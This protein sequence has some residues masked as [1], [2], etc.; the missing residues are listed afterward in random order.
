MTEPAQ[1]PAQRHA[2]TAKLVQSK[3]IER[4][5]SL[6]AAEVAAMPV[7]EVARL[8]REAVNVERA[9]GV[10]EDDDLDASLGF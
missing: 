6:T 9:S 1:T 8:W 2:A 4:F 3:V 5:L 7:D 10:G